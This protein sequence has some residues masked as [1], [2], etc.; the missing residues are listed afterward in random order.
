MYRKILIA[1]D[2]SELAEKVLDQAKGLARLTGAALALLRVAETWTFP[3]VDPTDAQV[4]V[5]EAAEKYLARVAE[6]LRAEGFKVS[7]HVR[8]GHPAGEIIDHAAE[9]GIDLVAMTTHG[10][11]GLGRWAIGGVTRRVVQHCPKPILIVRA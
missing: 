1:L 6:P 10:L 5:V 4:A 8:Y 9:E 7:C 3:G 11:T 2:G